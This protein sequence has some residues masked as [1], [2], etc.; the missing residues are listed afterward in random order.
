LANETPDLFK[1]V[2]IVETIPAVGQALTYILYVCF[3]RF[4]EPRRD[5]VQE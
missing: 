4:I 1:E 5:D 2:I 3:P